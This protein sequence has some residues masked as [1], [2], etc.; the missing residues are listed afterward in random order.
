MTLIDT[1]QSV[2]SDATQLENYLE[3]NFQEVYDFFN[4]EKY[5][6]L[7]DDK[8]KIQRYILFHHRVFRELDIR[9]KTNLS[10]ISLLLD[11]S[12][13]FGF[14]TEFKLLHDFL[15]QQDFNFGK[16]LLAAAYYLV[17]INTSD[18]YLER[19][20]SIYVNLQEAFETEEDSIDKVLGT[21]INYYGQVIYNFEFNPG[22]AIA[23]REKILHRKA[24]DVNTFLTHPLVDSILNVQTIPFDNAFSEIHRQLDSFLGRDIIRIFSDDDFLIE[25]GSRYATLLSNLGANFSAIRELS[26]SLY[27]AVRNDS[28][29]HSLQ[30]GVKILSDENQLLA[31][32]YSYGRMHYGKLIS[33]FEFLPV[34]FFQK[35]IRIIDWGCGQGMAT[36]AYFDYLRTKNIN[37]DI[38]HITLIEPSEIALRRAS[39]HACKYTGGNNILTVNKD[40]DS[41]ISQDLI[42]IKPTTKLHL[43]SNILDIDL[44]SL[45]NLLELINNNYDGEN[46]FICVSP[47]VNDLKTNRI[48]TFVNYFS[49]MDEFEL[50]A[51]I[52]N[53]KG[54]WIN[55]W[56]RVL[57]IF[58][59]RI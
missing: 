3:D 23:L 44:F 16:R 58:K 43:F 6:V 4:S 52:N 27:N 26:N 29:F 56:A 47:Y 42:N 50:L 8:N 25:V 38:R 9:N 59:V 15:H 12:E 55:D 21:L 24:T 10:F 40:L 31:Y 17:G 18:D 20:E 30:R 28:I 54:E 51:T 48:D 36:M 11:I 35:S 34:P 22:V 1:L 57:R 7:L 5:S 39:L 45:T 37:L 49:R 14:L 32:M 46:Y 19:F 53:R 41:L 13:R 33:A 2:S